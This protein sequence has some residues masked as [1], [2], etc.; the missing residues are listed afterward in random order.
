PRTPR[1]S[2]S[3]VSPSDRRLLS[4]RL[5]AGSPDWYHIRRARTANRAS[6]RRPSRGEVLMLIGH[7]ALTVA[8][9]FAGA[10]LYVSLVEHPARLEL[11]DRAMLMEW[12]PAYRR[13]TA[14][15]APLALIGCGLGLW[16]WWLAGHWLWLLGAALMVANWP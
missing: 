10:A 13:G 12:K 7:L 9:A 6:S 16:A 2:V 5:L 14:M 4:P 15:Q 11:D 3:C 8:A 1:C